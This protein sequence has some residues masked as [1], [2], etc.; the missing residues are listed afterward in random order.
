MTLRLNASDGNVYD[1]DQQWFYC[2][3]SLGTPVTPSALSVNSNS[4]GTTVSTQAGSFSVSWGGAN[5][6][7]NLTGTG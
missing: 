3:N 6:I 4:L 5:H 1:L 2:Y 7:W